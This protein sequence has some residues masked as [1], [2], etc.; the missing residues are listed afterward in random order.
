MLD[1]S[2]AKM[3]NLQLSLPSSPI[4]TFRTPELYS[5]I[6][7]MERVMTEKSG[8]GI[9]APQIGHNKR[10]IIFGFEKCKRYPNE[11]PVPF[12]ILINPSF[13]PLS[14]ETVDG[15]EGCLSVPGL[16]GLVP[17]YLK[18]EYSGFDPEGNAI[19]STAEGFHARIIQHEC[20]HL[21]GVLFP[22][23]IKDM[24]CFGYEEELSAK[25]YGKNYKEEL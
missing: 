12:T 11:K 24:A 15:W 1:K 23:R 21:D 20:D 17:R 22:Q 16:R 18:I 7:D 25:I 19:R 5:L 13:R 14:E 10:V 2:V 8:V 9:A 6:Q 3:G 4:E